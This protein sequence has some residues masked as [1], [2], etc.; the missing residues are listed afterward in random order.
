MASLKLSAIFSSAALCIFPSR[1][2]VNPRHLKWVTS[3]RGVP[4]YVKVGIAEVSL[5]KK[6]NIS[7]GA[8]EILILTPHEAHH[9]SRIMRTYHTHFGVPL[10]FGEYSWMVGWQRMKSKACVASL[11]SLGHSQQP[12]PHTF[13][14]PPFWPQLSGPKNASWQE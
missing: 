10:A 14:P 13:L 3:F 12:Q 2:R 8:G 4:L 1:V 9:S 7:L 11:P 5:L 6:T